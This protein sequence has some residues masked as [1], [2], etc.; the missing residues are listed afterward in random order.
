[1]ILGI[2]VYMKEKESHCYQ[3]EEEKISVAQ[4]TMVACCLVCHE[5]NRIFT[6]ILYTDIHLGGK[7]S[8]LTRSLLHRTFRYT[9]P[10][11]T[12]LVKTMSIEPAEDGSTADSLSICFS[13]PNLQKLTLEFWNIDLALLHPNFAQSLRSLSRCCTIEMGRSYSAK[14]TTQWQSLTRWVSFIRC[15]R[16]ASCDLFTGL[17]TG[18]Y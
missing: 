12:S 14:I 8:L 18:G 16:L 6:P 2:S 1:M 17:P 11:R 13:L 5:W 7:K 3:W 10:S 15:S 9:Q 4:R